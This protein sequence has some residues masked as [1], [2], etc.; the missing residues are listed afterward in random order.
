MHACSCALLSSALSSPHL[1]G[2]L[3][4][5]NPHGPPPL[6]HVG[7]PANL[8]TGTRQRSRSIRKPQPAC[9]VTVT[10]YREPESRIDLTAPRVAH[11]Q[12][13]DGEPLGA[14]TVKPPWRLQVSTPVPR[15][16]LQS[17]WRLQVSKSEDSK[18]SGPAVAKVGVFISRLCPLPYGTI[19]ICS[20]EPPCPPPPDAAGRSVTVVPSHHHHSFANAPLSSE[21]IFA[22]GS[23]TFI[24]V[25]IWGICR[26]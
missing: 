19:R 5:S 16:Q 23:M 7:R 8:D 18:C 4:G 1:R 25:R 21:Q 14:T 9:S 10:R 22:Y 17:L 6:G 12:M 24:S 11:T 13:L 26:F 3:R 20:S 15:I 2:A